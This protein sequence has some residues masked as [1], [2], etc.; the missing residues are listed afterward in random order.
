MTIAAEQLAPVSTWKRDGP[1]K[2]CI[3]VD[4]GGSGLRVR[5]SHFHSPAEFVD[6]DHIKAASTADSVAVLNELTEKLDALSS[7]FVCM[8]AALAVAGPIAGTRVVMTNWPGDE[9]ART[10]ELSELPQRIVPLAHSVLLNDL[11]A[12]AYGVLAASEQ[13][14]LEDVFEQLFADVGQKGPI[15]S[16]RRTAVCA[17]GSGY[18]VAMIVKTPLL[19]EAL[20]LGTEL[21]HVQIPLACD[22]DPGYQLEHD[23]VQHVSNYYYGGSQAPEYED[24]ASGRGLKLAYQYFAL[25]EKGEKLDV[26]AIDPGTLAQ[27]AKDGD[28]VARAAFTWHYKLFL[29]SAKSIATSLCCDSVV[30][31][32]DNQVKNAWFVKEIAD[33]LKQEFYNFIRPTWITGIRVYA[34]VKIL[35]FNVLGTDYMARRLAAK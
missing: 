12:G 27:Q 8:G 22:T 5:V 4:I 21:G 3:G 31:A 30:L 35:N 28:P 25:K 17:M 7:G 18:G 14:G 19:D 6:L 33:I 11:E 20:V 9:A 24:I 34:Q 15:V 1:L 13:G 10:I 2:V 32:L 16:D 26:D 23:L 29:R